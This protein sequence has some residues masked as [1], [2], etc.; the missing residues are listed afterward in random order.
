[1]QPRGVAYV[2]TEKPTSAHVY[3]TLDETCV[4][5]KD[6]LLSLRKLVLKFSYH[7]IEKGQ[8][9]KDDHVWV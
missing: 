1:M 6:R 8:F 7:A 9:Q 2:L 3:R 4:Y 5:A